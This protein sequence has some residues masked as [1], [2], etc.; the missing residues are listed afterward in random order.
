M[1]I[2][3]YIYI[4]TYMYIHISYSVFVLAHPSPVTYILCGN[5]IASV[6]RSSAGRPWASCSLTNEWRKACASVTP[7]ACG[8][9][10][11]GRT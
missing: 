1:Y 2:Y 11:T 7:D 8:A 5:S 10:T 4:H 6:G 9:T 3:I